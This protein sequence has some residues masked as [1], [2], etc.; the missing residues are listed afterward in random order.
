MSDVIA[1]VA[2][3][4]QPCAIGILRLS[5]DGAAAV[6]GRVFR[7]SSGRPLPEAPNRT[8]MRGAL[9]DVQG[10]VIDEVLAVYTRAPGSYTG[11]DTVELQ[12]HGSP[13]VLEV[14]LPREV[15]LGPVEKI[16]AENAEGHC[17]EEDKRP[18][19][20]QD[21]AQHPAPLPAGSPFL[22]LSSGHSGSSFSCRS[23]LDG[24]VV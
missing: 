1:A 12:C 19:H 16:D 18:Q 13:A 15:R 11:E 21:A 10:R 22:F 17:A 3:G 23:D 6:A 7:A 4:R 8:L 14:G 5:G 9:L 2:T 20:P 24:R